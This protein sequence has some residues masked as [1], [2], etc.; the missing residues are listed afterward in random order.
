MPRKRAANGSGT[1]PRLR[2]DGRWE[3]RYTAGIDLGTG[4]PIRKSLYGKTSEEVVKRLREITAAVDAKTYIEP[5]KMPLREWLDIWITE[6]CGAI[7]P[8]TVKIYQDNCKN[9]IVPA[10]GAVKLAELQPHDVQRFINDLARAK[11]LA[12]KTIRNIHGTLSKA[13]SEAVRIRYIVMNPASHCIMPRIRK[14][15]I[16]PFE[17][18]EIRRFTIAIK[19]SPFEAFFFLAL[20]TGMRLSELLGLQWRC[21]DFRKGT[22]RVDK[23]LLID[24]G[25]TG[26]RLGE[27]KNSLS[28][29]FKAAPAVMDCLLEVQRAQKAQKLRA[30]SAWDNALELVFT[31]PLGRSIAHNTIENHFR[32][33][34]R[35]AEITNHRFHD[36]RHTYATEALRA[37]IDAKSISEMLGHQ[38]VAFTL[39]V[40]AGFTEAMQEDAALRIQALIEARNAAQ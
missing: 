21:V 5:Q 22:I 23:Q 20:N 27:T 18:E 16:M 36:L 25:H 9:H 28:R 30:G 34:L 14:S 15:E 4:K 11:H 38:S 39:D 32:A 12:P 10:L 1:Q 17:A 13:L 19:D 40:Y 24:R 2:P 37:G 31:D 26:R 7:K 8:G 6:Y 33:A 3:I 35:K 29:T